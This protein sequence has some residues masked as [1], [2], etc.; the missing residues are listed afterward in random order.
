MS[1]FKNQTKLTFS[2][3][4]KWV[5]EAKNGGGLAKP[6]KPD[7]PFVITK[8]IIRGV[9]KTTPIIYRSK[10]RERETRVT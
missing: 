6:D 2:R 9:I 1:G 8:V 3:I 5:L 7:K 10:K 4:L